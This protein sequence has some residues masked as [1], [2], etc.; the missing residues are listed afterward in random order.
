MKLDAKM[1]LVGSTILVSLVHSALGH[2]L[3]GYLGVA[4]ATTVAGMYFLG[5]QTYEDEQPSVCP[6]CGWPAGK[7]HEIFITAPPGYGTKSPCSPGSAACGIPIP[8]DGSGV[9]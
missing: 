3:L 6:N 5:T 7:Q 9:I 1:T 8:A 4:A 2:T